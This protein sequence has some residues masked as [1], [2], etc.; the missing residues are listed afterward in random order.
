MYTYVCYHHNHVDT[1]ISAYLLYV[2]TCVLSLICCHN[3]ILQLSELNVYTMLIKILIKYFMEQ[4]SLLGGHV[5][6]RAL[7]RVP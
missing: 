6:T 3:H 5:S 2:L 7:F 1:E 4:G